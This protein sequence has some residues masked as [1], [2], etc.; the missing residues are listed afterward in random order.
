MGGDATASGNGSTSNGGGACD[1]LSERLSDVLAG[2]LPVAMRRDLELHARDCPRCS[3][4]IGAAV[5]VVETLR[6]LPL[7][8][9]RDAVWR[10]LELALAREPARRPHALAL[11]AALLGILGTSLA[12]AL[13]LR[14]DRVVAW[15]EA[16]VPDFL[17]ELLLAGSLR[18]CLLPTLFALFGALVAVAALPLLAAR[19]PPLPVLALAAHPE[20]AS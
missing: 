18:A 10:S 2:D 14:N 9:R 13:A 11:E 19:R 16:N 7:S 8:V 4:E 3:S 5:R 12:A 1:L 20:N 6:A 15:I 17:R